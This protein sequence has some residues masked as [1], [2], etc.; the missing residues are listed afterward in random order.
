M[1]KNGLHCFG[2]KSEGAA[3]GGGGQTVAPAEPG[4]VAQIQIVPA[5]FA[6]TPGSKQTFTI[7]GLD[8]KGR[9]V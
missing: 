1:T 8:D 2:Q 5:E 9:R 3:S 7:W 4:P 6:L